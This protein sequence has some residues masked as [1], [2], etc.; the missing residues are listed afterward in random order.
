MK[1]I[2]L[3]QG[4]VAIVDDGDHSNLSQFKWYAH[5]EKRTW[6][7]RTNLK[8][9]DGKS[10]TIRMHQLL[11]KAPLVDHRD[12]DGLNNRRGN[13]RPCTFSQNAMNRRSRKTFKGVFLDKRDGR[14]M[15]V[16]RTGGRNIALGRFKTRRA[17][18]EAYDGAARRLFG[19]FAWLNE[20]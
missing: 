8:D 2:P 20:K 1:K 9:P 16:I 5:R 10:R 3:T 15:A 7:A 11:L 6:Y 12:G 14:W 19:E 4:K 17:A 18:A 13:L